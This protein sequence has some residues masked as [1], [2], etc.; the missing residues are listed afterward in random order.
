MFVAAPY[1]DR[2]VFVA[3][4][5][6][7]YYFY[8]YTSSCCASYSCRGDINGNGCISSGSVYIYRNDENNNKF[9]FHQVIKPPNINI[10]GIYFGYN[11]IESWGET[12]VISTFYEDEVTF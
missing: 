11:G 1:E 4:V 7:I 3:I 6:T 12:V 5:V 10:R 9:G 8:P 2:Y